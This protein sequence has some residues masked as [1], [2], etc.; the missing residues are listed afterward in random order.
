MYA[1]HGGGNGVGRGP[2]RFEQIETNLARFKVDI[3]VADGRNEADGGRRKGIGWRNGDGEEPAA[4][5][6]DDVGMYLLNKNGW[7]EGGRT[8]Y[9]LRRLSPV[10]LS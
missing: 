5:C 3:G 2:R 6:V 8:R 9:Y 7:W 4:V 1:R 10:R